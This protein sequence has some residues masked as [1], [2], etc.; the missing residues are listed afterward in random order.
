MIKFIDAMHLIYDDS[1]VKIVGDFEGDELNV[2]DDCEFKRFT[3]KGDNGRSYAIDY[4][5][6]YDFEVLGFGGEDKCL[7]VYVVLPEDLYERPSF[8][9]RD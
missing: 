5:E 7:V 2:Y 9:E 6:F 1:D 8:I 4:D 3:V